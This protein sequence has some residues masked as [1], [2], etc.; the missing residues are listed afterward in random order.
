MYII[1]PLICTVHKES[2]CIKKYDELIRSGYYHHTQFYDEK[3][4]TLNIMSF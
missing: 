2:V 3:N 4:Y 1:D